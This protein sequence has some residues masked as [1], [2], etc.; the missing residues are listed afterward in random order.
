MSNT[1]APLVK[2]WRGTYVDPTVVRRIIS[3]PKEGTQL[4]VTKIY[5]NGDRWV[6]L[7][8]KSEKDADE[9]ADQIAE[10]INKVRAQ[11]TPPTP[12]AN[13]DPLLLD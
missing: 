3:L 9:A 11:V 13:T 6:S 10:K 5:L 12:P 7:S 4:W 1:Y 2:V 8:Y